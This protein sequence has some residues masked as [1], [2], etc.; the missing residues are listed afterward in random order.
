MRLIKGIAVGA[1]AGAAVGGAIVLGDGALGDLAEREVANGARRDLTEAAL[2]AALD[3]SGAKSA[4]DAALRSQ[5]QRIAEATGRSQEEVARAID[6]L[7]I[8]SWGIGSLPADAIEKRSV[9]TGYRGIDA[10]LT[11]YED[12]GYITLEAGGQHLTL[13]VPEGARDYI[14]YLGA[15]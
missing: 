2:N 6:G 13:S 5:T 9:E 1:A 15:L 4:I 3:A 10:V 14:S 8:P 11:I 12:P 7:D